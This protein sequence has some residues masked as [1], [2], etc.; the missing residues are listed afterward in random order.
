[1]FAPTFTLRLEIVITLVASFLT[2]LVEASPNY[3]KSC[4]N[5]FSSIVLSVGAI[6]FLRVHKSRFQANKVLTVSTFSALGETV[7]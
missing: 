1:M 6:V 5:L 3:L 4:P 2:T 7:P